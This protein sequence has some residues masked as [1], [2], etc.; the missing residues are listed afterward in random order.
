[1]SQNQPSLDF[2]MSKKV[3]EVKHKE[4]KGKGKGNR[5]N[6]SKALFGDEIEKLWLSG[7]LGTHSPQ[8]LL[9]S[10]WYF[11]TKLLGLRGCDEN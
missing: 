7:S 10:V 5:P 4:L 11:N 9:N 3:L 8:A 2:E 1:M 6:R